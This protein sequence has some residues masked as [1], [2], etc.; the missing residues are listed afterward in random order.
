MKPSLPNVL[1]VYRLA[2]EYTLEKV[3][4]PVG[5]NSQVAKKQFDKEDFQIF[6]SYFV[7]PIPLGFTSIFHL[8]GCIVL[9]VHAH[10]YCSAVLYWTRI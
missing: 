2:E 1:E 9:F 7:C 3:V 10:C 4:P 8:Y 5:R 6:I